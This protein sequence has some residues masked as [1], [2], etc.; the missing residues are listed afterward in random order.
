MQCRIVVRKK[1]RH[2][3]KIEI[4]G[5][6]LILKIVRQKAQEF[7]DF[8]FFHVTFLSVKISHEVRADF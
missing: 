7:S 6:E 5:T 1:S 8:G 4:D 2:D 3:L